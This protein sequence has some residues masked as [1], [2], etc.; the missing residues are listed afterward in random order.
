[1]THGAFIHRTIASPIGPLKLT[2]NGA[3]LCGLHMTDHA[4]EAAY[5]GG[6]AGDDAVLIAAARQLGEYFEGTRTEFD[7]PLELAGTEFQRRV[8]A[9]LLEIRHGE[10]CSYGEL[11]RAIGASVTAS[12]AVGMAN[13]SNPVSIL[14]PCHRVIGSDGTLTGYGGGL[15]NKKWLLEHEQRVGAFRLRG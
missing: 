14:V 10:R 13:G 5:P 11:A 15:A 6:K 12:R 4:R 3:A 9:G 2:S 1:M 8:W 7:V